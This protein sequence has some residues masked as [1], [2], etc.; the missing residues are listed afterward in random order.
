MKDPLAILSAEWIFQNFEA[1][2]VIV[3][4][5]PAAFISSFKAAGWAI[6]FS[7]LLLQRRM[8]EEHFE[9][10]IPLITQYS[11]EP[12]DVVDQGILIWNII[13]KQIKIYH[14]QYDKH[15]YFIKHEELSKNPVE[16]F[17]RLFNCLGIEFT[18]KVITKI[19]HTTDG[20]SINRLSR[21]S[22]QNLDTWRNSLTHEEVDRIRLGTSK[23]YSSFYSE[24]DWGNY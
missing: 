8:L 10:Y 2:V 7:H 24:Q 11:S 19:R 20:S 4:R 18:E 16:G 15:W 13:Y 17:R 23:L 14:N 3:L 9:E 6:L 1:D 5:H 21:N 12:P 22:M